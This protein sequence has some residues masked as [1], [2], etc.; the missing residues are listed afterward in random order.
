MKFKVMVRMTEIGNRLIE[1]DAENAGEAVDKA[2]EVAEDYEFSS[3]DAMYDA[4][5]VEEVVDNELTEG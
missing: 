2:L 4:E 5:F 1:V 3:H